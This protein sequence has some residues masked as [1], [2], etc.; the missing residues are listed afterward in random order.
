[1]TTWC[2]TFGMKTAISVPD[3]T[4]KKAERLAQRL[5]KSRSQLF[6]EAMDQYLARHDGDAVTDAINKVI[7][8]LGD[9]SDEFV[10]EAARRTFERSE[11]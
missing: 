11:W 8:E 6:S 9:E 5:K 2:Y 7:D 4:F 1:M 10:A 3:E